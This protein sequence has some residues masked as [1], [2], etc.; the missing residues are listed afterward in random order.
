MLIATALAGRE[1]HGLGERRNPNRVPVA[2]VDDRVRASAHALVR[3]GDRVAP[4][5]APRPRGAA[6]PRRPGELL[7][8]D[9]HQ[10]AALGAIRPRM[11]AGLPGRRAGRDRR[12]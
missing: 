4:L 1:E 2:A 8:P 7:D 3:G 11:V 12:P 10:L 5:R 9:V 6:W